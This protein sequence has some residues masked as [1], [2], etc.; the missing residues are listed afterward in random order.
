[1]TER[2]FLITVMILSAAYLGVAYY[3]I[4]ARIQYDPL[5]PESWPIIL[6][7]L[8]FCAAA[9][10]VFL[11]VGARFELSRAAGARIAGVFVLLVFYA[12]TFEHLGFVVSTWLFCGAVTWALG[13]RPLPAIVF[14]G[15]IGFGVYGLFTRL[16]DLNLP[17]GPLTFLE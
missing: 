12:A 6:G 1:M 17:A 15:A 10:R 2:L 5:G 11:P 4:E 14:G 13:T 7:A 16:L 9:I 3:L 8:A